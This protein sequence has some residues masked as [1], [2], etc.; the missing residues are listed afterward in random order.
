MRKHLWLNTSKLH[1]NVQLICLYTQGD[2]QQSTGVNI[3]HKKEHNNEDNCI[4]RAFKIST[5]IRLAR[6]IECIWE[7][8]KVGKILARKPERKTTFISWD[9]TLYYW[10]LVRCT[11]LSQTI[12]LFVCLFFM[13]FTNKVAQY[14]LYIKQFI[15]AVWLEVNT[16]YYVTV[17]YITHCKTSTLTIKTQEMNKRYCKTL[18]VKKV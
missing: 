4:M 5:R 1:T 11:I 2:L 17:L 7:T 10:L 6:H 18:T 9:K 14:M 8:H 12:F 3:W 16:K 15:S 13:V